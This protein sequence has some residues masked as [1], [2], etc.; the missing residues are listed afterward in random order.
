MKGG[1]H[2]CPTSKNIHIQ[3]YSVRRRKYNEKKPKVFV[4]FSR[5]LSL[6]YSG[7]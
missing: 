3:K 5:F 2:F 1:F 4:T 7:R 6:I